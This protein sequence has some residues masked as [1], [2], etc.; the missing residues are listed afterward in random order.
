MSSSISGPRQTSQEQTCTGNPPPVRSIPG[1]SSCV[2]TPLRTAGGRLALAICM[3]VWIHLVSTARPM[4]R[5][6]IDI[7][8]AISECWK[9]GTWEDVLSRNHLSGIDKPRV[10]N[11]LGPRTSRAGTGNTRTVSG[12]RRRARAEYLG[13]RSLAAGMAAAVSAP[14]SEP[15][16]RLFVHFSARNP[17]MEGGRVDGGGHTD[18]NIYQ[19][20]TQ[21]SFTFGAGGGFSAFQNF[22][23]GNPQGAC[24]AACRYTETDIDAVNRFRFGRY[25]GFVQD[26]WRIRSNL[27]LDLGL[28][29]AFYPPLKDANDMLFTFSPDAYDPTKAPDFADEEAV[30]LVAVAAISY[31]YRIAGQNSPYGRSIYAADT[32]NLQPR[33]GAAWSPGGSDRTIMRAGY[34]INSIKPRSACLQRTSRRRSPCTTLFVTTLSLTT[35]RCRIRAVTPSNLQI[36]L[37]RRSPTPRAI[38]SWR[39][40]GSIGISAFSAGSIPEARSMSAMS[41]HGGIICFGMSI[42]ISRASRIRGQR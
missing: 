15:H 38:P 28:R 42:S 32:N 37:S 1:N 31:G 41:G 39:P 18:F 30:Y 12:E 17:Y 34:G 2:W 23:R 7:V 25:E 29:Y 4:R 16:V 3:T 11:G 19:M 26:S 24:G 13:V 9:P 5:R 40:D 36:G 22:L 6:G 20:R 10:T 14:L 35:S 33:F 27:T 8:R 21:G